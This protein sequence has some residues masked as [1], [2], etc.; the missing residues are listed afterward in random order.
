RRLTLAVYEESKLGVAFEREERETDEDSRAV[1]LGE[2]R[3]VIPIWHVV[4]AEL[5]P[6]DG[7]VAEQ[8]EPVEVVQFDEGARGP[9]PRRRGQGRLGG[10][11][12]QTEDQRQDRHRC[13]SLAP[14]GVPVGVVQ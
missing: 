4:A 13:A 14:C 1:H 12:K 8:G 10:W 7:R 2:D 3:L 9:I 6:A 5:A 11:Q